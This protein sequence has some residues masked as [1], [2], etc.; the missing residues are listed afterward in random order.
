MKNALLIC[1][2]PTPFLIELAEEMYSNGGEWQLDVLFLEDLPEHRGRHWLEYQD[3]RFFNKLEETK[4]S[5]SREKL[6][7]KFLKK[8]KY[9]IVVSLLPLHKSPTKLLMYAFK[10]VTIP[11]IF[12]HEPYLPRGII[13]NGIKRLVYQYFGRKLPIVAVFCI[14]F[15]AEDVWS[16]VFNLPCHIV[17]YFQSLQANNACPQKVYYNPIV[18]FVFSGQLIKRNNINEIL[19]AIEILAES[20]S[21][22][23]FRVTFYGDGDLK[24]K[25]LKLQLRYSDVCFLETSKPNSWGERLMPLK[26]SDVLLSPGLYSGWGLT[27]PEALSLG[28]PVIST[29]G[30]ESARYFKIGRASCRERV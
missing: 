16:K 15:K 30:I 10:K 21:R 24:D 9:K 17:P 1:N 12:W 7:S 19:R 28:K 2:I 27:I 20:D 8:K 6:L 22:G 25:V 18:K 26:Q 3:S 14:G 4:G 11:M 29:K 13:V 5:C 23:K